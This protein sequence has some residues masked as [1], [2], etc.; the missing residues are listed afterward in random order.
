MKTSFVI[1]YNPV[2][3]ETVVKRKNPASVATA[4]AVGQ[5]IRRDRLGRAPPAVTVT[6]NLHAHM[7]APAQA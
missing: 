3:M 4:L 2:A 6:Q 5:P 7:N 1:V